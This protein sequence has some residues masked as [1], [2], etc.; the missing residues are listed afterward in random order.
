MTPLTWTIVDNK[1]QNNG[2]TVTQFLIL[3]VVLAIV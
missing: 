3:A 1:L 2:E